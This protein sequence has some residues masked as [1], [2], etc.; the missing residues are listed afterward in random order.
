MRYR[1]VGRLGETWLFP[2]PKMLSS[3]IRKYHPDSVVEHV[4]RYWHP[5]KIVKATGENRVY[6]PGAWVLDEER[7]FP[8]DPDEGPVF[9]AAHSRAFVRLRRPDGSREYLRLEVRSG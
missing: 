9:R 5:A 3:Y 2:R 6:L 8:W 1:I 7:V 4:G